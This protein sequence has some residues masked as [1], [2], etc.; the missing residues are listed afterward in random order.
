MMSTY[1]NFNGFLLP[2]VVRFEQS[3][4]KAFNLRA[5]VDLDFTFLGECFCDVG[6]IC[7][8]VELK[9]EIKATSKEE[10]AELLSYQ[11]VLD[12]QPNGNDRK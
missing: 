2:W 6:V 3:L 9:T 8:A 5:P 11:H 10:A 12:G 1:M 4:S 7:D